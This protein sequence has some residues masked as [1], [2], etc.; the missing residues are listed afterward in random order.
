MMVRT[1]SFLALLSML[2]ACAASPAF[3]QE[4]PLPLSRFV[5]STSLHGALLGAPQAPRGTPRRM[6]FLVRYDTTGTLKDVKAL[7][8]RSLPGGYDSTMVSLL[9]PH[10]VPRLPSRGAHVETLWLRSGS[11][12]RISVVE[13]RKVMPSL[14][15]TGALKQAMD[16]AAQRLLAAHPQLEGYETTRHVSFSIGADG[17]PTGEIT[18]R[19]SPDDDIDPEI[20]GIVRAMRFRPATIEGVPVEVDVELPITLVFGR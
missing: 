12:P 17:V 6:L 8:R 14:T 16:A 9:R 19:G 20:V 18:V 13:A 15:N 11:R 2:G 7:V 4:R 3:A 10:L 5:D 1:L